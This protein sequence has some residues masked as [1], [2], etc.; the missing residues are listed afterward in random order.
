MLS[1]LTSEEFIEYVKATEKYK[2]RYNQTKENIL[3]KQIERLGL[4]KNII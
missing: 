1:P 3:Q 4:L 2:D